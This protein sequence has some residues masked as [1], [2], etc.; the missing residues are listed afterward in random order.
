MADRPK[1]CPHC[2]MIPV[3]SKTWNLLSKQDDLLAKLRHRIEELKEK[4]KEA[5]NANNNPESDHS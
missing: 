4:L 3:K 5:E 2:G 1:R